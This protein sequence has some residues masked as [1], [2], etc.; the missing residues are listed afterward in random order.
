MTD[1]S[2]TALAL[3]QPALQLPLSLS[4]HARAAGS[5]AAQPPA[6]AQARSLASLRLRH[7]GVVAYQALQSACLPACV[8]DWI[9]SAFKIL[10]QLHQASH[11]ERRC[12]SAAGGL[13]PALR[14][15]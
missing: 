15:V 9:A 6:P 14:L 13:A 11:L 3:Q 4:L 7:V 12:K 1:L 5:A 2:A 10:L 8:I